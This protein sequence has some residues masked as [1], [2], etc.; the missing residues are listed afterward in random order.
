MSIKRIAKLLLIAVGIL[1]LIVVIVFIGF[2]IKTGIISYQKLKELELNASIIPKYPNSSVWKTTPKY[3][4][5]GYYNSVRICFKTSDPY[6]TVINYYKT[7]FNK[8]KWPNKEITMSKILGHYPKDA[9]EYDFDYKGFR[10]NTGKGLG[11][12]YTVRNR[13]NP[14]CN[15]IIAIS[16]F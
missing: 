2:Q 10:F 3:N 11:T 13:N 8:L 9:E 6:N 4:F 12:L 15:Y 16:N 5:N 7:E 14:A 1:L